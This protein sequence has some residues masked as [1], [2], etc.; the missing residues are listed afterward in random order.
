MGVEQERKRGRV[1]GLVVAQIV[2]IPLGVAAMVS[3]MLHFGPQGI[4][5]WPWD[6]LA[7]FAACAFIVATLAVWAVLY[8]TFIRSRAPR[9][10]LPYFLILLGTVLVID[11][12][13]FALAKDGD[14]R[15]AIAHKDDGVR[16]AMPQFVKAID[17]AMNPDGGALRLPTRANGAVGEIAREAKTL[18]TATSRANADYG[19]RIEA[20]APSAAMTPLQLV[21]DHGL[22]RMHAALEKARGIVRSQKPLQ[23][24]LLADYRAGIARA[25]MGDAVRKDLLA[26]IDDAQARDRSL[27]DQSWAC[28]DALFA[29]YEAMTDMLAR[30]RAMWTVVNRKF[31]FTE[32]PDLDAYNAHLRAID[33][34]KGRK[35]AI[36]ALA[37]ARQAEILA[38][39]PAPR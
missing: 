19:D 5:N 23:D 32:K 34:L 12:G 20:L 14:D 29:E 16:A 31:L 13:F 28:D 37:R 33:V 11:G 15:R 10:G 38:G 25:Q 7:E 22:A 18:L 4:F 9:R 27:R 26:A 6:R 36:A 35:D 2:A 39:Q 24:G 1:W 21:A 3:L 8:V 17:A 30:D